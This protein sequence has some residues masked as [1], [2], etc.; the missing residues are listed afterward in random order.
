MR[1]SRESL[2]CEHGT[3]VGGC[4]ADYMC[5]WCESGTPWGQYLSY[6]NGQVRQRTHAAMLA[7]IFSAWPHENTPGWVVSIGVGL[8]KVRF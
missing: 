6:L 7:T 4:G 8:V 5:G 1:Q 3:Y 2:Y